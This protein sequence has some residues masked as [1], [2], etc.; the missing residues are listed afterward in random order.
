M[1]VLSLSLGEWSGSA[2]LPFAAFRSWRETAASALVVE[3]LP[4]DR[5]L[6]VEF[7]DE[8]AA[9]PAAAGADPLNSRS[10]ANAFAS[11]M[12]SLSAPRRRLEVKMNSVVGGAHL[13][14]RGGAGAPFQLTIRLNRPPCAYLLQ[15]ASPLGLFTLSGSDADAWLRTG[16]FAD[17]A[18]GGATRCSWR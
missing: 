3:F 18:W 4:V 8:A 10:F 16:D 14:Q 17:G 13:S 2:R 15:P 12:T 9:P 7:D 5:S 6:A 11:L 1:S